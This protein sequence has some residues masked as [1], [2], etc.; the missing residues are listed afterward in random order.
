[1]NYFEHN[2]SAKPK[3]SKGDLKKWLLNSAYTTTQKL[4]KEPFTK[5]EYDKS[6]NKYLHFRWIC[7]EFTCVNSKCKNEDT[8]CIWYTYNGIALGVDETFAEFY[9]PKCGKFTFVEY[10]RDSS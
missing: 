10:S 2:I 5:K 1:M 6:P 4:L 9:C 3:I 8:K 7:N